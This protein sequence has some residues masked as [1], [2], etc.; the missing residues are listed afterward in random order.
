MKAIVKSISFSF[1][2]IIVEL[3]GMQFLYYINPEQVDWFLINEEGN[4]YKAQ[5]NVGSS[6]T[7]DLPSNAT[8]NLINVKIK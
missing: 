5:L 6:I 1:N 7:F 8:R 4:L 3:S 2:K